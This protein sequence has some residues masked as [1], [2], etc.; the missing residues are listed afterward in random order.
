MHKSK[1]EDHGKPPL[2]EFE[3][4]TRVI[5][6]LRNRIDLFQEAIKLVKACPP[7]IKN[8]ERA[9]RYALLERETKRKLAESLR[10]LHELKA[11]TSQG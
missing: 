5:D 10:R 6:R 1:D 8:A 4:E 11:T 9:S 7:S 2:S 3:K